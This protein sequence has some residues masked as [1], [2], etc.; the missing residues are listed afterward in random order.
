MVF[1]QSPPH[2]ALQRYIGQYI[3]VSFNSSE[4]PSL[5]QTF[6]PYDI[7]AISIF[8]GSGFSA[9]ERDYVT[10]PV[11]NNGQS[12]SAYYNAM[13]T[14]P[15]SLFFKE[16]SWI[17]AFVISFKSAG[18][19]ELFY[20]NVAELT[21]RLFDFSALGGASARSCFLEQLAET[22]DFKAQVSILDRF[23]LEKIPHHYKSTG[24]I[25]EAC[26]RL[27]VTDG[28][29]N[30]KGLAYHTNMSLKTLE[31]R[32]TEK[33]GVSPKLFARF[34]RFHHALDL[35]NRQ[36]APSWAG[37]AYECGYYDQ[38]H[39]IKEFKDFTHQLPSAYA[40]QEYLLYNQMVLFKNFLPY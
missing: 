20:I 14:S 17:K 12:I 19:S 13:I 22:S 16:N 23:F 26:R 31:R 10:N 33:V 3:Y 25:G 8:I 21:N 28:L 32:F 6:L 4:L 39:F 7:T 27:I 18:F 15:T 34:K 24:Q 9:Y 5:K 36:Q 40:P 37:I 1:L 35:M 2:L 11:A 29:I 30:M 38:N